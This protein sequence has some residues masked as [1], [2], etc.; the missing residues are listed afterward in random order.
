MRRGEEIAR[1][2]HRLGSIPTARNE[3]GRR[4]EKNTENWVLQNTRARG[5][6]AELDLFLSFSRPFSFFLSV[7]PSL[8]LFISLFLSFTLSPSLS[9]RMREVNPSDRI[10][11]LQ[12]PGESRPSGGAGSS[13]SSNSSSNSSSV[14][15]LCN[16]RDDDAPPAR[17]DGSAVCPTRNAL[18]IRELS[19]DLC[20]LI[21]FGAA[22][23]DFQRRPRGESHSARLLARSLARAPQSTLINVLV[24]NHISKRRPH[25]NSHLSRLEILQF[26]T[27]GILPFRRDDLDLTSSTSAH[28]REK[29]KREGESS[30]R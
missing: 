14:A 11:E 24:L 19:L 7:F 22:S 23:S 25:S 6:F 2:K 10:V 26:I 9:C 4:L 15:R 13:N 8:L 3:I 16:R 12:V 30:A 29:E 18:I 1:A 20:E 17:R 21:H 28:E 27:V 5:K